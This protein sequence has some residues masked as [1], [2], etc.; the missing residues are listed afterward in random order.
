MHCC[1]LHSVIIPSSFW[2]NCFYNANCNYASRLRSDYTPHR[3]TSF[4]T[5]PRTEAP[6]ENE[7]RCMFGFSIGFLNWIQSSARESRGSGCGVT[8]HSV[9]ERKIH[10][11][12]SW[13]KTALDQQ[14]HRL[15]DASVVDREVNRGR[16]CRGLGLGIGRMRQM[17]KVGISLP[18]GESRSG[19]GMLRVKEISVRRFWGLRGLS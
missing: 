18:V 1:I 7:S 15:Y 14:V 13:C 8:L 9:G 2:H 6:F 5:I 4:E 16:G 19:G 12:R 3:L 11:Y 17:G 10:W